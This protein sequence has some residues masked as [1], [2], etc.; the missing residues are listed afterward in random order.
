[1]KKAFFSVWEG[2]FKSFEDARGDLDAWE[3]DIWLGKQKER[4][5]KAF[6]NYKEKI[7][8][9]KDYP[10][11]LVVAM[12]KAQ[13]KR[14]SILDFG[15]GMGVHYLDVLSKVP[16][17]EKTIQ[18]VIVDGKS[19]LQNVPS[20]MRNF[21]NLVYCSDLQD[22]KGIFD[23][24]HIGSTLQY[25]EN[26]KEL[27]QEF[28]EKFNPQ[29]FVFSDLLAGD[30]PTFVSHQIFY[31]K[32]IPHL[33]VNIDEFCQFLNTLRFT[34]L[35]KTKFVHPILCQE[36]V[37]PNFNLPKTHQMDRSVNVVFKAQ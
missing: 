22:V 11:S 21:D 29:Y 19:T 25:I 36:E 2:V 5:S 28:I 12:L 6:N 34:L 13:K 35:F 23:V 9:S 20:F 27:L 37:F 16:E 33:F 1:M 4:I 32:K 14:I 10:L 17:A 3:T 18:Y 30:I 7:S 31:E 26:W 24:V 15:G 8:I